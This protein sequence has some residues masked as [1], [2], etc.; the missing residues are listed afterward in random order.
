MNNRMSGKSWVEREIQSLSKELNWGIFRIEWPQPDD[1]TIA[2]SFLRNEVPMKLWYAGKPQIV[3]FRENDLKDV[4][5]SADIQLR[6][7]KMIT[8]ALKSFR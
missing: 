3:S 8:Q 4:Q 1:P 5:E 6:L 2:E 7:K